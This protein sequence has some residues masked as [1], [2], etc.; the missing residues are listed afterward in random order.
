MIS[1]LI[2]FENKLPKELLNYI[3]NY[4]TNDIAINA[5]KEYFSYLYHK[6][7]LY[8]DF[9]YDQYIL[10][11]CKCRRYYN[12][13]A[14]RWKTRECDSCFIFDSTFTYMSEDFRMCIMDNPQYQKIQYGKNV[15]YDDEYL[16]ECYYISE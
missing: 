5:L 6:K 2:L 8:E 16:E 15:E 14:Q 7:E 12:S 3:Q 4:L 13:R 11:N 1:P 9:V 10:P